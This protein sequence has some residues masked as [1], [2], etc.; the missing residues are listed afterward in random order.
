MGTEVLCHFRLGFAFSQ[1]TRFIQLH[2]CHQVVSMTELLGRI[3]NPP[4]LK[5]LSSGPL[6]ESDLDFFA[7][8]LGLRGAMPL[9]DG[10]ASAAHRVVFDIGLCRIDPVG[11]GLSLR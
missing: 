7:R 8:R 1:V 3:K 4:F 9:I 10:S 5:R 2:V 11:Q 6:S